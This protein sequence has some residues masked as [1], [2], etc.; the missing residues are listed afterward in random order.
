M[1]TVHIGHHFYGS[2]NLGDDFMMAGFLNA[3]KTTKIRLTCC[4]PYE[5]D[6]LV[7]RFPQVTWQPYTRESRAHAIATCDLWL[8]LGGSPFQS[9]VSPWFEDHLEYE[10]NLCLKYHKTMVFL[11]IGG[12]DAE[13][14]NRPK[15]SS[16]AHQA[17]HFWVRDDITHKALIKNGIDNNKISLKA[18]LSHLFFQSHILP[19]IHPGRLS[20]VLNFDYGTWKHL[21][22]V[23]ESLSDLS[24]TEQ[25]WLSQELR[26]LP[27]A[28]QALFEDLVPTQ[29][30]KW[31]LRMADSVNEGLESV[32]ANW[33][34]SEW[35]LSSR[36]H[37]TLASAWSGSKTV[38]IDINSKLKAV[39]AECG[40]EALNAESSPTKFLEA[41]KRA[42]APSPGV[43]TQRA[44]LAQQSVDEFISLL[45]S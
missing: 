40:Y 36:F 39:A 15:L 27:G 20:T 17:H 5:L 10:A 3:L 7:K 29:R 35:T 9:S 16:I 38:V 26:P 8:G 12:Q 2:G 31:K 25:I 19:Q 14:Y 42:K 45:N 28:E 6:S 21:N 34:S 1:K 43:L 32:I 24:P 33:P 22:T 37:A 18:D 41:F 23:I 44:Y 11:G 30:L 4:V 13:A